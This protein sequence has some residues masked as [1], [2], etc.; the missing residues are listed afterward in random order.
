MIRA[1]QQECPQEVRAALSI[2][3][4]G[5]FTARTGLWWGSAA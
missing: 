3:E 5:S 1:I 4:D 2:E